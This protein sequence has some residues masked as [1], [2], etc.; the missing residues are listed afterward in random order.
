MSKT[1]ATILVL[2]ATA[3]STAAMA[4]PARDF[5]RPIDRG[6]THAQTVQG[7][8]IQDRRFDDHRVEQR[9]TF[10]RPRTWDRIVRP[11][12]VAPI[13]HVAPVIYSSAFVNGAQ[14]LSLGGAAGNAVELTA[15]G[16][17]TFVQQITLQYA[18]GTSQV[19]PIGRELDGSSPSLTVPT[20]GCALSGV[21]VIGW[22]T[23]VSAFA[24]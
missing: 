18:N 9:R 2:A 10:Y 11:A 21:S 7:R 1:L 13:A 14:W 16:G 22:G 20:D 15:N 3:T 19:V 8:R 24:I 12:Y 4:A 17:S 23:G 6:P 5:H